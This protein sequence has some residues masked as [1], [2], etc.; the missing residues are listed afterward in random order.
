LTSDALTK[1]VVCTLDNIGGVLVRHVKRYPVVLAAVVA[2]VAATVATVAVSGASAAKPPPPPPPPTPPGVYVV[3]TTAGTV[4]KIDP[5]TLQVTETIQLGVPYVSSIAIASDNLYYSAYSSLSSSYATIGRYNLTTK[6]N[7]PAYISQQFYAPV[8]RSSPALPNVLFVGEAGLSPAN[9]QKWSVPAMA[10]KPSRQVPPSLLAR[11]EHGPMGSNLGDY[12]ISADGTKVWSACGYPYDFVELNTSD[13]R[14][15]GRTFPAEPYPTSVDSVTVGGTEYLLG[16]TNSI[17]GRSIHLYE[18]SDPGSG[19]HYATGS[20]TG[21]AGAVALS[22]DASKIYRLVTDVYGGNAS[23]ETLS[24]ATGELLATTP[25]TTSNYFYEG[26][27]VDPVS[28]RV[29]VAMNDSVGV[30]NPDGT[31]LQSIPNVTATGQVLI[32]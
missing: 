29:F 19:V 26:I 11:T 27:D 9:I 8:L 21:K 22:P 32:P 12:Q 2:A 24:A 18:A 1:R 13:L 17:Y 7:E 28:G 14:L 5:A 15:S 30:L 16:G 20:T 25:V 4:V 6:Q 31:L 3:S 23:V 10:K